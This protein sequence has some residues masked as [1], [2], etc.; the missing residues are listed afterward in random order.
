[1]HKCLEKIYNSQNI[2]TTK[3]FIQQKNKLI[4]AQPHTHTQKGPPHDKKRYTLQNGLI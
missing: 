3:I 4:Y 1:M 2:K